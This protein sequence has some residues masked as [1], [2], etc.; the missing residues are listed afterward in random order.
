MRVRQLIEVLKEEDPEAETIIKLTD[1]EG[2]YYGK[3]L[4]SNTKRNGLLVFRPVFFRKTMAQIIWELR[5]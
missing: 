5:K 3:M 4:L 1:G 2:I